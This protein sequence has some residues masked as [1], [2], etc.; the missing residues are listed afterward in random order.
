[1]NNLHLYL[2]ALAAIV[3][4]FWVI[5]KVTSCLIKTVVGLVLLAALAYAYWLFTSSS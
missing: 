4:G 2:L 1:M 3:V 5:K